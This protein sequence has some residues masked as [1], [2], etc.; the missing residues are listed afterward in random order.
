MRLVITVVVSN[1]TL[2][3][4]APR[5]KFQ[6]NLDCKVISFIRNKLTFKSVNKGVKREREREKSCYQTYFNCEIYFNI[7]RTL[8][9]VGIIR[10]MIVSERSRKLMS[11]ISRW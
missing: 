3:L 10:F 5:V 1:N 7:S 4:I 9:V 8:K 2:S 6:M 11:K